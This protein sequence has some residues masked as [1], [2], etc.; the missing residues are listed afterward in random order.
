MVV[1]CL[2]F[3]KLKLLV[4]MRKNNSLSLKLQNAINLSSTMKNY[5]FLIF[6]LIVN[7]VVSQKKEISYYNKNNK[8]ISKRKFYNLKALNYKKDVYD[9]TIDL[10][11]ENDSIFICK[12]VKRRNY[13]KLSSRTY[14]AILNNINA[15]TISKNDLLVITFYPGKDRC[16]DT[17]KIPE[18]TTWD[19]I[20]KDFFAKITK[21]YDV[22]LFWTFKDNDGLGYYHPNKIPW[23]KDK[24]NLIEK[25][26]FKH[27]Y[28]CFSVVAIN[29]YGD[30]ISFY[31]EFGKDVVL[32]MCK[33]LTKKLEMHK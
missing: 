23:K 7:L 5:I 2:V 28:P 27:H 12:L 32:K 11:F 10:Y 33:E 30:Y 13:G 6:F 17:G 19:F 15:D 21:K 29:K 31:A 24:N 3:L 14:S 25:L 20:D 1:A 16:N 4:V 26:F 22:N 18:M 8:E 9:R